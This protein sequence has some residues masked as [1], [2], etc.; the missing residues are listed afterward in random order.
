V[1][2]AP[3]ELDRHAQLGPTPIFL[4]DTLDPPLLAE[5]PDA[6]PMIAVRRNPALIARPTMAMVG[7]RNASVNGRRIAE[8]LADDSIPPLV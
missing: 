6:P 7:A 2:Q 1:A 8:T 4:G 3:A 5:L